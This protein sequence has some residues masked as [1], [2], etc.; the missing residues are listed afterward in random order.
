MT[1][2]GETSCQ[3]EF[4]GGMFWDGRATGWTLNDPLAEQAQGPFLNRLEMNTPHLISLCMKVRRSAYANLFREVWGPQSLRCFPCKYTQ[5]F[6]TAHFQEIFNR[7][8]KSIASFERSNEMNPFNSK[9]DDFWRNAEA[10][11]L[12]VSSINPTNLP[13][14]QNLGLM[15]M[16]LNGLLI[17]NTKG[18]CAVCHP[19]QTNYGSAYP[20]FT[21]FKYHNLGIP[22][23]PLNPFYSMPRIWNPNGFDWI[24]SGL[25]GFLAKTRGASDSLGFPRDYRTFAAENYGKHKTPTLRNIDKRPFPEFVKSYGHN[26]YFKSIMEIVH[27]YN[28]RDVQPICTGGVGENPPFNCTPKPEVPYNINMTDMGNLGLTQQ[29]GM[30]LIAFLK[31]LSDSSTTP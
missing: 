9:F 26:G 22:K 31:T 19:L 24:D 16:E 8:A 15:P 18:K 20:L 7:I 6:Y 29:E 10:A 5:A 12:R 13:S 11:G 17:F 30:A 23:N 3:G 14:Y 27:F 1:Y 4:I 2:T 28:M 21:D 25:G